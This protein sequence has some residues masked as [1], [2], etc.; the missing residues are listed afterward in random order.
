MTKEFQSTDF[1]QFARGLMH[2]RP[3]II[4]WLFDCYTPP[5]VEVVRYGDELYQYLRDLGKTPDGWKPHNVSST[6]DYEML[7]ETRAIIYEAERSLYDKY[8]W[9]KDGT[10]GVGSTD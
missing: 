4:E 1:N 2:K 6:H 3:G 5:G 7:P 10:Y 9:N 8:R